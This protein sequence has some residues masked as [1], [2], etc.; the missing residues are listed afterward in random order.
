MTTEELA[1]LFRQADTLNGR[2]QE[3]YADVDRAYSRMLAEQEAARERAHKL[4]EELHIVA[5]DIA[6]L[7]AAE[8]AEQ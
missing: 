7:R 4:E 1:R 8:E 2:I 6:R 3:A 5:A